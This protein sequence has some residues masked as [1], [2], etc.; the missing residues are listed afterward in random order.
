MNEQREKVTKAAT[1]EE[2]SRYSQRTMADLRANL[3]GTTKAYT[4]F[5]PWLSAHA[6]DDGKTTDQKIQAGLAS[7]SAVYATVQGDAIP[8][9]PSTWSAEHPSDA[10]LQTPFGK[11]YSSV[12]AAVDPAVDGSIV[13][14]MNDAARVLGFPEFVEGQ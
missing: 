12:K 13:A 2:E 3:E 4:L 1:F 14:E 9:P 5:A 7:L 6:G 10:D 11:L 8:P